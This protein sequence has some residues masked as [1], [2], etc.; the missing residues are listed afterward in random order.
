M[1][2]TRKKEKTGAKRFS[3]Y[4]CNH[5]G[6]TYCLSNRTHKYQKSK[7]AD[8]F[9][10]LTIETPNKS[11]VKIPKD[12]YYFESDLT[13]EHW[14]SPCIVAIAKH[15]NVPQCQVKLDDCWVI[16]EICIYINNK[17]SGYLNYDVYSLGINFDSW[18]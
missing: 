2:R 16:G 17:W 18:F 5:G 12:G 6:C 1:S 8:P 11:V 10:E 4:C 3:S 7:L 14:Y 13:L 9:G 15:F